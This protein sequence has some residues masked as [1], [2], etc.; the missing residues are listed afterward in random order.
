MREVEGDEQ[1]MQSLVPGNRKPYAWGQ[2]QGECVCVC[3]C[4]SER[5]SERVQERVSVCERE[6]AS[7]CA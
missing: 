6:W 3:V 7:E 1:M 4:V 2:P 5:V